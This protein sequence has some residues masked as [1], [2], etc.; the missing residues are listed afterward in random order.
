LAYGLVQLYQWFKTKNEEFQD[1]LNGD[2]LDNQIP[3]WEDVMA[4]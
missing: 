2:V 3:I 4:A 1:K